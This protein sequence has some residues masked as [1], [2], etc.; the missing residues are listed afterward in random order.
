MTNKRKIQILKGVIECF[1]DFLSNEE[2]NEYGIC[3]TI[4]FGLMNKAEIN[5]YKADERGANEYFSQEFKIRMPKPIDDA[6]F[7]WERDEQGYKARIRACKQ[8]IKEL[9]E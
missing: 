3:D 8:A 5:R 9:S 1:E 4:R 2:Y 7:C 6:G